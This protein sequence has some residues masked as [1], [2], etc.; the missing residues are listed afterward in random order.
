MIEFKYSSSNNFNGTFAYLFK[1]LTN[2]SVTNLVDVI[3]S[4]TYPERGFVYNVIN[5]YVSK[6]EIEENWLSKSIKNSS[7]T[8]SFLKHSFSI[9]SYSIK[10]RQDKYDFNYPYEFVLEASNDEINWNEIHHKTKDDTLIGKGY[11]GHWNCPSSEFYSSYKLT[12]LGTNSYE[13]L[14]EQYIFTFSVIELFGTLMRNNNYFKK[15]TCNKQITT[16]YFQC[17]CFILI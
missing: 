17:F 16:Y 4:S 2:Y 11:E 15:I 3:A 9:D 7:V 5:P 10:S 12:M 8:I 1:H 6:T 13:R 14:N